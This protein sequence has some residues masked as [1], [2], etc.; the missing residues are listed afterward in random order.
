MS[1]SH[2]I[3]RRG[4]ALPIFLA[5]RAGDIVSMDKLKAFERASQGAIYSNGHTAAVGDFG[6]S[7]GLKNEVLV[8][9][10]PRVQ[11]YPLPKIA[12]GIPLSEFRV[13]APRA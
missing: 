5:L 13:K 8:F 11:R 9:Q 10:S 2:E 3:C 6:E 7:N 1:A 4:P 12:W